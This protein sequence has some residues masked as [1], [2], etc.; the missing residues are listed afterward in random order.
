MMLKPRVEIELS[1]YEKLKDY[2][3]ENQRQE[4]RSLNE[5]LKELKKSNGYL[6]QENQRL[7]NI[8]NELE[9]WLKEERDYYF[10]NYYSDFNAYGSEL[11]DVLNKLQELKE[12]DK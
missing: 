2:E 4:L 10:E 9:K 11:E 6:K 1:E 12:S 8:F 3:K 7:N 5:R